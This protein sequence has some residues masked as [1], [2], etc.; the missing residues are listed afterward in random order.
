MAAAGKKEE[1]IIDGQADW[2]AG[3]DSGRIPTIASANYPQG[4]ARDKLAWGN[5]LT[6][7][8]GGISPRTGYKPVVKGLGTQLYQ[9]GYM[10]EPDFAFPYLILQI[11]G[12][13]FQINVGTDNSVVNLSAM[14]GFTNPP[15]IPQ[16]HM[17]QGEQFLVIQAGDFGLVPVPTNPLFWDGATLRRSNGFISVGNPAN[18]LPP[19]NAMDYYMGRLWYARARSYIAGDIVGGPSGSPAYDN[20]DS[21]LKVTENPIAIAGDAFQVPTNA[22]NI[23]M[24]AHTAELD[25]ALGQGR[26]LIGT[27]RAIYRSNVPVNRD[28]WTNATINTGPLQTVAQIRYGP[29]SDRS[30]VV[31]NGD[32][33]YQTG[34]PGLRSLTYAIRYFQQWGN[35]PISRNEERALRIVDRSLLR[36][37]SGIEFDN[38]L[39]QTTLPTLSPVGVIHQGLIPLDFDIISSL[40]EKRPPAWEGL[41]EGMSILQLFEGDFG[42]LQRAFAIVLSQVS[43]EIEVWEMTTSDRFDMEVDNDGHR[44]IFAP[45]FPSYTWGDLTQLKEL[46]GGALYIDKML[47]K[48]EFQLQYRPDQYPCW[49]DWATWP[50]CAAKD[51]REDPNSVTCPPYPVQP[52]CESFKPD[53]EFPK[54]NPECIGATKRPSTLGYQFQARLIIKGW[55][56]IRGF[57]LYAEPRMKPP[58]QNIVCT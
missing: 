10:Y 38:R 50:E 39:L 23:R 45:E 1:R 53:M 34:E 32:L 15:N 37:S 58:Y 21:I 46:V 49:L 16:A 27:P 51:C 56:R 11:G 5:N 12:Q 31:V 52:F 36:F 57:Y 9:G 18:E 41:L 29:V 13:I 17:C 30:A 22:L 20:R 35:V 54:P 26:L 25:T 19:A 8:G 44:I 47:G 6:V 40:D 3:V 43:G 55:C 7:R 2:S 4:L 14:F 33:F 42:G 28:D 48:V 24:L